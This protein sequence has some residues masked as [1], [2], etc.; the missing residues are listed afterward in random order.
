MAFPQSDID[1]WFSYHAP[2]PEQLVA[3]ND[4]RQTAK[5]FAETVN[6]HVPDSAD[7]TSAMRKI[8]ESV[9]AANLAVACNAPSSSTTDPS[10]PPHQQ[11]VVTEKAELEEKLGKL[12]TFFNTSTY[13]AMADAQNGREE[14]D[15][16][17]EQADVMDRYIAILRERIA[18]F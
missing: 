12:R 17:N 7:K 8:R 2:T 18:A 5:I 13:A 16:L 4:I 1:N 9:M 6:K 14:Q 15:R 10:L 11:R 3:Y